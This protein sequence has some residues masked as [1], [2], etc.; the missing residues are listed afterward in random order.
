MYG[1]EPS[2]QARC[3]V[4]ISPCRLFNFMH[5]LQSLCVPAWRP[6]QLQYILEQEPRVVL[7]LP[8]HHFALQMLL[9]VLRTRLTLCG[10]HAGYGPPPGYGMPGYGPPAGFPGYGPPAG[11]PGYG[12]PAGQSPS[13]KRVHERRV[14]QHNSSAVSACLLPWHA[15]KSR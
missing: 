6:C 15:L 10:A 7:A 4:L 1:G 9:C 11:F 13:A 12:P 2:C 5:Y 8:A 14:G 3:V